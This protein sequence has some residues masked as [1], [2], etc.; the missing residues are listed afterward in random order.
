MTNLF[1]LF[2]YFLIFIFLFI[3]FLRICIYLFI[4]LFISW[5][6]TLGIV[7]SE[8]D[9]NLY[10]HSPNPTHIEIQ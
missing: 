1:I 10:F 4:Y 3:Y 2:I 6:L 9:V 7:S 8:W 5:A